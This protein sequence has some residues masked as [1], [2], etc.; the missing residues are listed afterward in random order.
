VLDLYLSA[1]EEMTREKTIL[2]SPDVL[3]CDQEDRVHILQGRIKV[4]EDKVARLEWLENEYETLRS[5]FQ[6]TQQQASYLTVSIS[7]A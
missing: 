6:A 2:E 5:N 1:F 7:N 3:S 4:L